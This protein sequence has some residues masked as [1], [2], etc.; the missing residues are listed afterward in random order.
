MSETRKYG[1]IIVP[2]EEEMNQEEANRQ[3]RFYAVVCY[4]V[5]MGVLCAYLLFLFLIL[6]LTNL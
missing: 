5:I 4:S 2:A 3:E 6:W 1:S